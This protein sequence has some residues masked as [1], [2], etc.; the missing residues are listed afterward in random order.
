MKI[1]KIGSDYIRIDED[2]LEDKKMIGIER[3]HIIKLDFFNPNDDKVDKVLRL[4]PKT[5]RF[6]IQNNIRI[7]N[8]ILKT[9][10]KKYYCENSKGDKLLTFF[11]KNNKVLLN[12]F[13]L[14]PIEREFSLSISAFK[15]ILKNLE[16]ILID[17]NNY[18]D[19]ETI[20]KD[21]DGNVIITSESDM[22]RNV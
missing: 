11:R 4:Y 8:N 9:T 14:S 6:V 15:D 20:L 10:R 3:V 16:V 22:D 13:N 12:F 21:W 5:N 19:K 1:T 7:Y 2:N 17:K 18:L